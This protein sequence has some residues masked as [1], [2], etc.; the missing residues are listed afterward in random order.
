MPRTTW[1]ALCLAQGSV[2]PYKR[3]LGV[4]PRF[5]RHRAVE[6]YLK[7]AGGGEL[8]RSAP[9]GTGERTGFEARA[10]EN[11]NEREDLA[12]AEPGIDNGHMTALGSYLRR[13]FVSG[14]PRGPKNVCRQRGALGTPIG[15]AAA[16][17]RLALVVALLVAVL[18]PLPVQAAAAAGP[19]TTRSSYFNAVSCAS[20]AVCVAVG[21]LETDH[22]NA[23]G[24]VV[25]GSFQ[26]IAVRTADSGRTWSPVHLPAIDADL[27]AV[28]CWSPTSC[29]AVGGTRTVYNGRW[30]SVRAVVL[31]LEGTSGFQ[32]GRLPEGALALDGVSCPRLGIC[33]AVGGALALGTLRLRPELLV[34][35]DGGA[36]WRRPSLP[37]SRGQLESVSCASVSSCVAL[38]A[39]SYSVGAAAM[40]AA[41]S[42]PVGLWTSTPATGWHVS[43]IGSDQGGGPRSVSCQSA[44]HCVAV[45]DKFDWCWC[46]TGTP[47][48]FG[49][50]WVTSD[51][52]ATWSQVVLPILDGYVVWY[53]NAV[54]CWVS[55]CAMGATL[56]TVK[57]AS[58]YYAGI[59]RLGGS[60]APAGALATSAGGLRPQYVLGLWCHSPRACVAV[61]QDWAHPAQAAIETDLGGHWTTTY[62]YQPAAAPTYTE[63]AAVAQRVNA[64]TQR[65]GSG[66]AIAKLGSSLFAEIR[67]GSLVPTFALGLVDNLS[68]VSVLDLVSYITYGARRGRAPLLDVFV[69]AYR[70][71]RVSGAAGDAIAMAHR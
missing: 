13:S 3:T 8:V 41:Q 33:V 56:S 68:P 64:L 29:V 26:P 17:K 65:W 69:T 12:L 38:G 35:T 55:G 37:V 54:S 1:R 67:A 47:G 59:Q 50:T 24:Q 48:E 9:E 7:R 49:S 43:A 19:S 27:R 52:G 53:A 58:D 6:R 14:R 16:G 61:G 36:A 22:D 40:S 70:T 18:A 42:K 21:A 25:G 23:T 63:G 32:A 28:S 39:T 62:S 51:G 30:Y 5:Y 46:G 44:R 57:S 11:L 10:S 15:C 34:S 45:G 20:A 2:F 60:G 66:W 4:S 31:R 71:A